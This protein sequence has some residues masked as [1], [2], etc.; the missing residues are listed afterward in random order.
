MDQMNLPVVLLAYLH[1]P[2]VPMDFVMMF[3]SLSR[4]LADHFKMAIQTLTRS[5]HL[6]ALR[7]TNNERTI[8]LSTS[9]T[10]IVHEESSRRTGTWRS[11]NQTFQ[12]T[13]Q[14]CHYTTASK[15]SLLN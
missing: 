1:L 10:I 2:V 4:Y 13:S 12:R 14:R 3:C 8:G 9:D 5:L 7:T 11:G 6:I 15:K